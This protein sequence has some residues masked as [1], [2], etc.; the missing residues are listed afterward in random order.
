MNL[1]SAKTVLFDVCTMFFG[2][3][4]VI[5]AEQGNTKPKLPYVTIKFR[6]VQRSA[7]PI[8]K[9]GNRYY[10][11]SVPADINLYS[12]GKERKPS[13]GRSSKVY[14][15]TIVSDFM[16]FF[17]FLD[18]ESCVDLIAGKGM[19]ISLNSAVRDLSEL[20]NDSSYR[21][22]AM[23]EVLVSFALEADGKYG[24]SSMTS[25]PNDSGGGSKE[26]AEDQ[27]VIEEVEFE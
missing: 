6:D 18:S 7:F 22:R 2:A 27:E 1:N 10:E 9:D 3:D 14:E 21:Y 20:E 23:A 13:S 26:L 11:C 19:D 8:E 17:N 12:M 25:I 5:W 4:R 16:D 24:I 15:N